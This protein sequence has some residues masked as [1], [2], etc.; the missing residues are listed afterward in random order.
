MYG[1]GQIDF[2]KLLAFWVLIRQRAISKVYMPQVNTCQ[3]NRRKVIKGIIC[4]VQQQQFINRKVPGSRRCIFVCFC[5]PPSWFSR[6]DSRCDC[7]R[8]STY[9]T[10][11]ATKGIMLRLEL[12]SGAGQLTGI[13]FMIIFFN[14]ASVVTCVKF[15]RIMIVNDHGTALQLPNFAT[16]RSDKHLQV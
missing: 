9:I 12:K 8:T 3:Q 7:Q 14:T 16:I 15:C 4:S 5:R 13:E 6:P 10:K 11:S 2:Y 1:L